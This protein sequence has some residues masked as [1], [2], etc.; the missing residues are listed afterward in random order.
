MTVLTQLDDAVFIH[1]QQVKTSSLKV[2]EIFKKRHDNVVRKIESFFEDE[3]AL[4]FE[5][6]QNNIKSFALAQF[7]AHVQTVEI[8]NGATRES[9]YYEMTKDGFIFLVMGFTG[10]EAA[11]TKI[12][13]INTFNQ[14]A[15]MLYNVQGNLQ[16]IHVGAAVQLKS[17]GPLYT[18][19]RIHYDQNGY[20]QDADVM[21][22]DKAKLC[23]ETIPVACLSLEQKNLIQ[24]KTLGDFWQSI[25]HYGID[26]LN[27]SRD[28]RIL[29]LNITQLYQSIEGLPPKTQLLANLMQS[30]TPYPIYM[31]H[32][33]AVSSIITGKTV[34]C[35][36]F[37]ARQQH[38]LEHT[39]YPLG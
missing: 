34:K 31:Q 39:E 13:Y 18:V 25:N 36:I 14:M 19:S 11:L 32:N 30:R 6:M 22:H 20:M 15:A 17:G 29:A 5:G 8:G 7:C 23:R 9:K 10:E 37:D 33:H 16:H 21:W 26:K 12:A 4:N 1:D 3:H 35:W 24:N 2:A 28:N 27:H 38:T